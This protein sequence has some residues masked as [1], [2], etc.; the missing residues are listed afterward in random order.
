MFAIAAALV[1]AGLEA[2]GEDLYSAPGW[3]L[4]RVVEQN[5]EENTYADARVYYALKPPDGRPAVTVDSRTADRL[6]SG[7]ANAEAIYSGEANKN[8]KEDEEFVYGNHGN[9]IVM[10]EP[11]N[12]TLTAEEGRK[13]TPPP[14]APKVARRSADST[15]SPFAGFQG[16]SSGAGHATAAKALAMQNGSGASAPGPA[17]ALP[18]AA[19]EAAAAAAGGGPDPVAD[20]RKI[21][22]A[23]DPVSQDTGKA[24]A[25]GVNAG[26][27]PGGFGMGKTSTS[28]DTNFILWPNGDPETTPPPKCVA[29]AA[30]TYDHALIERLTIPKGCTHVRVRA[31]GAGGGAGSMGNDGSIAGS[32]GGGGAYAYTDGAIDPAKYDLV[33]V[34][35]GPGGDGRGSEGGA[36]GF[37]SGG[38]GG[39]GGKAGGGGGG[40]SG[41]F[42][43][44]RSRFPNQE[45]H[46][47]FMEL[48]VAVAA[49][50]G[51]GAA[52][53]GQGGG[54]GGVDRGGGDAGAS[55]SQGGKGLG[56]GQDGSALRGGDAGEGKNG[57]GGG[58]G[59]GGGF[60][61][62]GGG[63]GADAEGFLSSGGGGGSTFVR[64][65]DTGVEKAGNGTRGGNT[66][67]IPRGKAGDAGHSGLVILEIY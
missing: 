37:P 43:V 29:T 6:R 30:K 61:G 52:D 62:G 20:P 40:Y 26:N 60:F 14:P 39:S 11:V 48:A 27:E 34:V 54:V 57:F 19:D 18:G 63:T 59:G 55:G 42:L 25:G 21:A 56:N 64:F 13:D 31:W 65:L 23:D 9:G 51:G 67:F 50:G 58:G 33:V 36:P 46:P 1:F 47:V 15:G 49:G 24:F 44:E 17:T 8:K 41:L 12:S 2:R 4:N 53:L 66:D 45:E 28:T 3:S 38:K 7:E 16:L 5:T 10:A 32:D 35:G 22:S